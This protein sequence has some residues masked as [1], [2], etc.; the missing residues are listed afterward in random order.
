MAFRKEKN[1]TKFQTSFPFLVF[2][3]KRISVIPKLSSESHQCG[4]WSVYL[5]PHSLDVN[6][7]C[8]VEEAGLDLT[9]FIPVDMGYIKL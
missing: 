6:Q 3:I 2:L 1:L 9:A 4:S 8:N 7:L 5:V